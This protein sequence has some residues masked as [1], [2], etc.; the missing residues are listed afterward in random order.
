MDEAWTNPTFSVLSKLLSRNVYNTM[1]KQMK[2]NESILIAIYV[3][4]LHA[5]SLQIQEVCKSWNVFAS[6]NYLTT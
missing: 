6:Q 1:H 4:N 5:Q 3:F 2:W